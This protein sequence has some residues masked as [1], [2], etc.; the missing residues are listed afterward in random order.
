MANKKSSSAITTTYKCA[1]IDGAIVTVAKE[2]G[3]L[4]QKIH[5]VAVSI[6]KV[7]HDSNADV[8]VMHKA[9]ERL[10]ALQS[11]SPYHAN[12][13]AIWVG[14]QL[15]MAKWSDESKSWYAHSDDAK[16]MGKVFIAAR[17]NP[18]WKVAPAPKVNPLDLSAEIDRLIKKAEKRIDAP[19]E[20]DVIALASLKFLREARDVQV[21]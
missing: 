8:N 15:P 1:Q 19:V 18:F 21:A 17:D 3:S 2:A 4:Q 14:V 11:A 7:W 13:F 16:L 12:A 5:N 10:N 20:G 6:L 9:F